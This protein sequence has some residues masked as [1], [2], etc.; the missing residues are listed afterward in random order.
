M[1]FR[2]DD[3]IVGAP[4][5]EHAGDESGRAYVVFGKTDTN[6]IKL[7]DLGNKGFYINI[8]DAGGE[9]GHSV[10]SAGDFNGDGLDDVIV[11]S[12]LG[13][14]VVFGKTDSSEVKTEDLKKGIGG[15]SLS[16]FDGNSVSSAGDFN[17]DGYDDLIVGVSYG[18]RGDYVDVGKSYI[19]FGGEFG[20]V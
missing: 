19:I 1:L 11:G 12:H 15:F 13:A 16:G 5:N 7:G 2:S 10:S 8:H 9:F 14:Y 6:E 20:L 17:G 3:L 18:D 4:N